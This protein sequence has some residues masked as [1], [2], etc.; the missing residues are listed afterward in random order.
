MVCSLKNVELM[1][2]GT[3][4]INVTKY[5]TNTHGKNVLCMKVVKLW[6]MSGIKTTENISEFITL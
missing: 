2:I 1:I 6:Y 4:N 5:N 3:L